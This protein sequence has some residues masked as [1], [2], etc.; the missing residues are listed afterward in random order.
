MQH[1]ATHQRQHQAQQTRHAAGSVVT[2]RGTAASAGYALGAYRWQSGNATGLVTVIRLTTR[3]H[4]VSGSVGAGHRRA[5]FGFHRVGSVMVGSF[6]RGWVDWAFLVRVSTNV[7]TD[8]CPLPVAW[9][10]RPRVGVVTLAP[11]QAAGGAVDWLTL[12]S[13]S[14]HPGCMGDVGNQG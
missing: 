10:F 1:V 12:A 11:R 2:E 9:T 7:L 13:H 14:P 6:V 8:R 5:G 4:L 3:C